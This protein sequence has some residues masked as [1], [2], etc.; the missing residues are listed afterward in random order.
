MATKPTKSFIKRIL[1]AV[2]KSK[3]KYLP[4]ANLSRLM[5]VYPDVLSDALVYFE[6]MIKLDESINVV[7]LVPM[8]EKY[9][10]PEPLPPDVEKAKRVVV[11]KKEISQY[12]SIG[13]FVYKK[14]TNVGG[15]VD[16]S[17]RLSDE[18]LKI[19]SKLVETEIESRKPKKKAKR[20]SKKAKK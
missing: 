20:R 13:D 10:E 4:L 8:M 15:L 3:R 2:K 5:G 6:P 12:A 9:C 16:M 18:D 17:T 1:Q 19:L 14:F 7:S 11:S